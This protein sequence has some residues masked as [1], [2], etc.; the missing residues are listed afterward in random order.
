ML[1]SITRKHVQIIIL[2]LFLSSCAKNIHHGKFV[3]EN[4]LRALQKDHFTKSEILK[5]LGSPNF[6]SVDSDDEWYYIY[7]SLEKKF[8][9]FKSIKANKIVKII[10]DDKGISKSV[11][12]IESIPELIHIENNQTDYKLIEN[13]GFFK[14]ILINMDKINK[15]KKRR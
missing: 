5:H 6:I 14:Q 13:N 15:S 11:E 3:D 10:F 1:F 4:H 12:S 9:F 7:Q 2:A 8:L